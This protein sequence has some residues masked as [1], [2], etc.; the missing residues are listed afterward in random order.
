[1]ARILAYTYPSRGHLYP[2]V[3]T[4]QEL[5]RRR[6]EVRVVTMSGALPALRELGFEARAVDPKLEAASV[7]D[8][9]ARTPIGAQRREVAFLASRAP[10]EMEDLRSAADGMDALLVDTTTW[11]A[12]IAAEASGLPWAMVGHFPLPIASRDAPPYGLGLTPRFDLFG[13]WRDQLAR[14]LILEPLGRLILPKLNVLRAQQGLRAVRDGTDLF[15]HTAPLVLYYTAEPFEYPRR[16]W[17]ESV[18]LVGPGVWDPPADA[19]AWLESLERPLV[20]VTCSSE[21]QDDGRLARVALEALADA[22]YQVV[23]TTA[24]VDPEGLPRPANAHITRYL[25]HQPLLR[26]AACVVCH[27]GMGITQKALAYGVPVC[28]VPFGRDQFEVARRVAVA[29]AGVM[30]A[31]RKLRTPRLRAA[32]EGAIGRAAGARR[33]AAAYAAAGG[34]AA[35]ADAFEQLLSDS[36]ADLTRRATTTQGAHR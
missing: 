11:G 12:Q 18:R 16:D 5:R 36:Q 26:S 2:A 21:F 17:P 30:L 8:W 22:P 35:A 29:G 27:A 7:D 4:L 13:R 10:T 15:A 9:R 3:P 33:I 31:G 25:P 14:R 24:A 32:V 28:A 20:L 6:H 34:A 1:M 23:V 19:P